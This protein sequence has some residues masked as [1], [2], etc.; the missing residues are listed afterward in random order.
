MLNEE[1]IF[2]LCACGFGLRFY[3]VDTL[4]GLFFDFSNSFLKFYEKLSN[5]Y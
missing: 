4:F 2:G 3:L 5:N 1:I